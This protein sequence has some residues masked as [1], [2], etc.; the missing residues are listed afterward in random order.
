M[1]NNLSAV[2]S[3]IFEKAKWYAAEFYSAPI[4][5]CYS[6]RIAKGIVEP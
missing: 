1:E 4:A 2:Y 6:Y 5:V 3:W